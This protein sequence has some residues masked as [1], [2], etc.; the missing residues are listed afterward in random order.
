[1]MAQQL[2]SLWC[3]CVL[4]HVLMQVVQATMRHICTVL[5]QAALRHYLIAIVCAQLQPVC[6]MPKECKRCQKSIWT[7]A[8]MLQA[9]KVPEADVLRVCVKT[10]LIDALMSSLIKIEHTHGFE[11]KQKLQLTHCC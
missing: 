6:K 9:S 11:G 5:L 4:T 2:D 3:F 8:H 10:S 1:M 7:H